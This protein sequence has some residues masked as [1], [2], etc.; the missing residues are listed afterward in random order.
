MVVRHYYES[1]P[2]IK[3]KWCVANLALGLE[4]L[5]KHFNHY[6]LKGGGCRNDI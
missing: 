1:V 3:I 4:F 6:D 5:E 2:K